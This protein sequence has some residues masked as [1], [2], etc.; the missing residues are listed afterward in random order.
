MKLLVF[1][2]TPPPH[3]G[4]SFMV[5]QLLEGLRADP[6]HQIECFHVDA[7]FSD[8]VQQI[9]RG[10][11]RKILRAFRFAAAALW[12]RMRH[13]VRN[14]YYVPA[15]PVRAAIYRDWIVMALCRPFFRNLIYHWHAV[16]LGEWLETKARPWE[17][18]LSRWLLCRPEL[19]LVLGEYNKLDATAFASARTVVVPNGIPDSCPGYA[20]EVRPL[21]LARAQARLAIASR[22]ES[23]APLYDF[24]VLFI[25]LCIRS[26]GLFDAVEAVALANARLRAKGGPFRLRLQ[27]AGRFYDEAE[28]EEFD[29][30]VGQPDLADQAGSLI[31]YLGFISGE[32]KKRRLTEADAL[33]FPTYYEAESFGLVVIEAM[34]FG[35]PVIASRWRTVPELFPPGYSGLV[36]PQAPEQIANALLAL[37]TSGHDERLRDRFVARYTL[38]P[39][40]QRVQN[41]VLD[42]EQPGTAPP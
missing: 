29:A 37:L 1:A 10:S 4:Q 22:G 14:F 19:S 25:G 6:R 27:V 23:G 21:R 2:H 32:E 42:L 30:R 40:V 3:H 35:L 5:E 33:V 15:P 11:L 7:R 20:E 9:G 13:G 28:K 36:P 26:K 38:A 31:E 16:G 39:F 8:D 34:A 18:V 41:A 17:R 12:L 24:T